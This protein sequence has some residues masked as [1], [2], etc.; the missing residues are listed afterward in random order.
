M[1]GS[2]EM[3]ARNSAPIIASLN[4]IPFKYAEVFLPGLILKYYG[5]IEKSKCNY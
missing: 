3:K 4:A 2:I 1:S 5:K